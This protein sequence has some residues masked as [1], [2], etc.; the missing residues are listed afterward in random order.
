MA[1]KSCHF[2][3]W[4]NMITDDMYIGSSMQAH[5]QRRNE[6]LCMLRNNK[7][8]NKHFQSSWNK[9]GE[10][11]FEWMLLETCAYVD[12]NGIFAKEQTWIDYYRAQGI[13]LYNQ[14]PPSKGRLPGYRH[15]KETRDKISAGNKGKTCTEAQIKRMSDAKKGITP[16]KAIRA[17]IK[18][19]PDLV[20]PDGVIHT[21]ISNLNNF[22]KIHNLDVSALRKV[23]V[24][25]RT[26]HK[27]WTLL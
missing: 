9:H 8:R 6:H 13:D 23:C 22:A 15:S 19:W 27:N 3:A 10:S 7:H 21:S 2:Y 18:E 25:K 14:Y 11:N 1:E 12:A 17:I 24:G 16:T 4:R 5:N 26:N 20:S